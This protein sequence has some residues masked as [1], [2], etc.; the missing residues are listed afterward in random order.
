MDGIT[1]CAVSVLA[2][3]A[4]AV[5]NSLVTRKR[6]KT[7]AT[8]DEIA[9][10]QYEPEMERIRK[11]FRESITP[12]SDKY[13]ELY[14]KNDVVIKAQHERYQQG[15]IAERAW[16]EAEN[17]AAEDKYDAAVQAADAARSRRFGRST[18]TAHEAALAAA[19]NELDAARDKNFLAYSKM[20][21]TICADV[22]GT[23]HAK[24]AE[25][26][27]AFAAYMDATKELR[28]QYQ[29]A[30]QKVNA[31]YDSARRGDSR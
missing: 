7:R 24:V 6:T 4:F 19:K 8:R 12:H 23:I 27:A 20:T 30:M 10:S 21:E 13:N 16:L 9:R 15:T 17:R 26:A 18:K 2:L 22:N 28:D 14:L 25:N 5:I 1:V 29:L 31:D 3:I 11:E